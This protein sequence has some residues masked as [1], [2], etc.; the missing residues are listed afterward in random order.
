MAGMS[1]AVERLGYKQTD[2]GIL[3]RRPKVQRLCPFHNTLIG[4]FPGDTGSSCSRTVF[5]VVYAIVRR[6]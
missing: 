4:S 6:G 2:N 3:A 5:V 1:Q